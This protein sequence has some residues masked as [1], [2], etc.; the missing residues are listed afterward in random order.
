ML[1]HEQL[2]ERQ[3]LAWDWALSTEKNLLISGFA[4][5]GKTA[6]I[7]LIRADLEK[8][9]RK[10]RTTA[11]T[12][13]A[14]QKI[15]GSTMSSL[16]KLGIAKSVVE[17]GGVNFEEAHRNLEGV[18]D[19]ILDEVSM[20]SGDFLELV[21]EILQ[22]IRGN[23]RPFGGLRMIF[24]G[25]F[26][27]LPPVHTLQ[28]PPAHR[29]WAFQ[30]LPVQ[31]CHGI[32]LN[33]SMRQRDPEEV[34]LLNQFRRGIISEEGQKFLGSAL[35]RPLQNPAELYGRRKDAARVNGMKLAALRGSA[36]RYSTIF[37]PEENQKKLLDQVPIESHIDLKI[38]AP[39]IIL[40][41]DPFQQ[42]ANGTQGLIERLNWDTID[43]RLRN[44]QLVPIG[45]KTWQVGE[46]LGRRFGE[47]EGIPLHLGWA[48]TIHRAQGLTLDEVR[49]DID[50][51]W[52][53]GQAYVA[54]S[55]T[56]TLRRFSLVQP[57]K[58]IR[59][60]PE[61]LEFVDQLEANTS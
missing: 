46:A 38:G 11:F 54:L 40:E 36:R 14:A 43:I 15:K 20:C 22:E 61:V 3:R 55:R 6:L 10:V 24:S 35:N 33:E 41:N 37:E 7:Q 23:R 29:K 48:A 52:E 56:T 49:A 5:T 34:Y 50:R 32:F 30:Y 28:D 51:C 2:T 13:I 4:G 57:V 1:K 59:V 12:G 39:V 27:Q 58:S 42:Y 9:G 31:R 47:V 60:A 18:T 25:D 53:P 16:L 21:D 44:G 45:Y 19:I 17:I 26:L 8:R